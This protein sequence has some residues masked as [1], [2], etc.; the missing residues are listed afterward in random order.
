MPM[1]RLRKK[2]H[3]TLD[4]AH[5]LVDLLVEV[6][7]VGASDQH[8]A[9]WSRRNRDVLRDAVAKALRLRE[10]NLGW[11]DDG[12]PIYIAEATV[13]PDDVKIVA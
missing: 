7:S 12:T 11:L 9:R 8:G 5:V 13:S 4:V 1:L 6:R 2:Q 10:Q 3:A